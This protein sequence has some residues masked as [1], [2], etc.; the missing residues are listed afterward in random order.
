VTSERRQIAASG[1]LLAAAALA[2]TLLLSL[3]QWHSQPYVAA[4]ERQ[5]LLDSLRAVIP[6]GSLD[7]DMLSDTTEIHDPDLL[8]METATRIYRAR[9]A[10]KPKAVAFRIVAPDGYAGDIELLMG[11]RVD[12]VV[13]GVRVISHRETPGLGDAIET[14]RSPWIS[15]FTGKSL[16]NPGA[17]GWRVRRDGGVFDQFTGATITPRAVVGAVH[18]GLQFFRKHREKLFATKMPT[19]DMFNP[20]GGESNE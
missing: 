17:A 15:K 11:I 9:S 18:R 19:G 7:N 5:M 10:G 8:G 1:G 20:A 13:S 6:Q 12:G 2:G 14:R 3:T 16:D 4:N